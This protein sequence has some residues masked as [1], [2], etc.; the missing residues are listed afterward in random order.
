MLAK[1]ICGERTLGKGHCRQRK[2]VEGPE[3]GASRF[4]SRNNKEAGGLEQS[5][6]RVGDDVRGRR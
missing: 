5:E 1:K 4:C 6:G 3:V 2:Q